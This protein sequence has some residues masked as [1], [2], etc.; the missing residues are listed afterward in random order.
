MGE[1]I[2]VAQRRGE[3]VRQLS[4]GQTVDDGWEAVE[5]INGTVIIP[6]G[7][8]I[9]AEH[10][11][12]L[13]DMTTVIFPCSIKH[14]GPCAFIGCI[15]LKKMEL[16]AT[17]VTI[18][19][20][21]FEDADLEG[22]IP[23]FPLGEPDDPFRSRII[24]ECAFAKYWEKKHCCPRCG[25]PLNEQGVCSRN[26]SCERIRMPLSGGVLLCNSALET[27]FTKV[28]TPNG[29]VRL[30]GCPDLDFKAAFSDNGFEMEELVY[31][32]NALTTHLNSNLTSHNI[33][34]SSW[35]QAVAA[36]V[37]VRNHQ[38]AV[39]LPSVIDTPR[40]REH[41]IFVF[42]LIPENGIAN[43][44]FESVCRSEKTGKSVRQERVFI[45]KTALGGAIYV[46]DHCRCI[47]EPHFCYRMASGNKMY[48]HIGNNGTCDNPGEF[49]MKNRWDLQN[50]LSNP[51][52]WQ[53][54]IRQWNRHN[55]IQVSPNQH[56]PLYVD[57]PVHSEK[58]DWFTD[59]VI[60]KDARVCIILDDE[61]SRPHFHYMHGDGR[62]AKILFTEPTYLEPSAY[63]NSSEK[64]DLVQFLQQRRIPK[65]CFSNNIYEE[66]IAFWEADSN[67]ER[68]AEGVVMSD[69]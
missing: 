67:H 61:D 46:C 65:Y 9:I 52:V 56:I 50:T 66:L 1:S 54:I 13:R 7:V 25:Y 24:G 31:R 18:G 40:T 3:V 44:E 34:Q 5:Q 19:E 45:A 22:D 14:I 42:G 16:P 48:L 10:A 57:T 30:S 55:S 6:D 63:L 8:T 32:T 58:R 26:D 27:S 29:D 64:E 2:V 11:F 33:A 47:R 43:V 20:C 68:V 38:A 51:D 36:T 60:L 59:P 21:A 35:G 28:C 17:Y 23:A 4:P 69:Y 37:H 49:E 53:E 41:I 39:I 62:E 15:Y 12:W